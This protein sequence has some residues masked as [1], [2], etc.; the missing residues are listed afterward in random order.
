MELVR[1]KLQEAQKE[2]EHQILMVGL[3]IKK[4]ETEEAEKRAYQSHKATT[5]MKEEAH[6][7]HIEHLEAETEGSSHVA[8]RCPGAAQGAASDC[9]HIPF[10]QKGV[11][12]SLPNLSRD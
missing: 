9:E 12:E 1:L 7:R 5:E 8:A 11:G 3:Q 10:H 2:H 6:V 4:K